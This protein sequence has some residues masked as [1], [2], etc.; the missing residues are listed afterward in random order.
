MNCNFQKH[1]PLEEFY[2]FGESICG[3]FRLRGSKLLH[4]GKPVR[5]GYKIW[6]GMTSRGYLV[7]FAPSQGSLFTKPDWGLDRGGCMVVRFVDALQERGPRP[8]H[9]SFDKVFTSVKLMFILR[10]KK[11]RSEGHRNCM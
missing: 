9:I 2:S 11:K 6:C 1:D 4:S 7:W 8:Y 10:K 3:Y 5:L